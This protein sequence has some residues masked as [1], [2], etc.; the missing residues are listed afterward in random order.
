MKSQVI[1]MEFDENTGEV[2]ETQIRGGLKDLT[3]EEA[4]KVID[5]AKLFSVVVNIGDSKSL[6]VHPASTTH[7]QM[8]PEELVKAGV[9]PVTIRLSI[10]LENTVDLI[11]DLNQ[12]LN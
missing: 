4:K 11:E 5:S 3:A 2:T 7:S 6:I 1:K 9:N 8:S 12:A 10:G